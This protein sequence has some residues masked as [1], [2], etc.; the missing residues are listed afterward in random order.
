MLDI[1]SSCPGM[2][3]ASRSFVKA[4][5]PLCGCGLTR[6]VHFNQR[7]S[8]SFPSVSVLGSSFEKGYKG[9]VCLEKVSQVK[10]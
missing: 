5:R 10:T 8:M 7:P 4:A 2:L 1:S 6:R 9:L 3:M